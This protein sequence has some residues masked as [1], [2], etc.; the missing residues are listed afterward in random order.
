MTFEPSKRELPNEPL[1]TNWPV[2]LTGSL[3]AG[4]D[5]LQALLTAVF[6]QEQI[7]KRRQAEEKLTAVQG[8]LSALIRLQKD[9]AEAG[10]LDTAARVASFRALEVTRAISVAIAFAQDD[11]VVCRASAGSPAPAVGTALNLREG[12]LAE[13]MRTGHLQLCYDTEADER[14]NVEACRTLGVRSLVAIPITSSS[15]VLGLLA[16]FASLP[17]AFTKD[18]V[19]VLETIASILSL[20]ASAQAQRVYVPVQMP[21]PPPPL[22]P[23]MAEVLLARSAP[24]PRNWTSMLLK[25]GAGALVLLAIAAISLRGFIKG[26]SVRSLVTRGA[27]NSATPRDAMNSSAPD[28]PDTTAATPGKSMQPARSGNASAITPGTLSTIDALRARATQGDADAQFELGV[29]YA[30][31]SDVRTNDKEAAKWF[32]SAARQGDVRAEQMLGDFYLLGRGVPKDLVR[33]YAWSAKAAAAGDEASK[34]R[35][36]MLKSK[37]TPWQTALAEK[38]AAQPVPQTGKR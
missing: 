26:D 29:K 35:V 9:A 27:A 37:L 21:A 11:I 10:D 32:T 38:L 19:A 7:S 23:E 36:E 31:G 1:P 24:P 30:A 6:L 33:A 34:K 20:R 14:V 12:L 28:D 15:G 5:K 22:S 2:T 8:S 3:V 18:H 16:V 13:C 4:Q 25:F 17:R